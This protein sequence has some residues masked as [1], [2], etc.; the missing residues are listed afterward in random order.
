MAGLKKK[1]YAKRRA[2]GRRRRVVG[3]KRSSVSVGV[4]KYVK[5]ALHK[6]IENKSVQ[7]NSGAN[8]GSILQ[9]TVMNAY[10]MAPLTGF[11]SIGQGITQGTRV[12]NQIRTRKCY[13]NYVLR[14]TVY[15]AVTNPN[16]APCEVQLML[17]YVKN[18]PCF[19]PAVSDLNQLFQSGASVAA[20][21][22]SLRDIISVIN[23]DYWVIKK[24]WTHKIGYGSSEGSGSLGNYEFFMNNDFKYNVV[25]RMDITKY[26]PVIYQ[27][28]DSTATPT[29]KNLFFMFQSV[30]A[31][32]NISNLNVT[33]ANI[34]FWI[35]YHFE[36]A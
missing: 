30:L 3:R 2:Y 8:F 17:G 29:S 10:P 23:T 13:L 28:N 25:R 34:E 19:A 15:D 21:V 12:G 5:R 16:P 36:D 9:N 7:I 32:G 11:W 33:T 6:Q 4:K 1:S 18:T 24:R 20:P 26:L 27:F 35:D 14:P 22:G 31:N